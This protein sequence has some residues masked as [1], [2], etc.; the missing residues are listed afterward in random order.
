MDRCNFRFLVGMLAVFAG[1]AH[2]APY[3]NGRMTNTL[4]NLPLAFEPNYGQASRDARFLSRAPGYLL[5]LTPTEVRM[6]IKGPVKAHALRFAWL[7]AN[8]EARVAPE[9]IL[10]GHVNYFKGSDPAKWRTSIPTYER[11]RYGA[12][13]R[14]IDLVYYGTGRQLEYDLVVAPHADPGLPRLAIEGAKVDL[15]EHGDLNLALSDGRILTLA[16]PVAYQERHGKRLPI[17]AGYRLTNMEGRAEVSFHV[18]SYDHELPLII[19]PLVYSTFL[20]GSG[21]DEGHAIAVNAAGEAFVTG[22]S[23]D[24]ATDFPTTPGAFAVTHGGG[25]D[26][27]VTRVNAAGSAL[28]YSTFLGGNGSDVGNGI[29]I[30]AANEAFVTG[31]TIGSTTFFPTT[32]GA[33]ST[34]NSGSVDAFVTRLNATGS[35]LVYSTLLGGSGDDHGRAI[36]VS[37][38]DEAFVTGWTVDGVTDYPTTGGAFD[39]THNGSLDV[40]VTRLNAAGSSLVYSTLLGGSGEDRG[41]GIAI[42]G[43][44][45]AFV[46]GQTADAVTDFPTTVGAFDTTHNGSTDA[47]VTRLNATGTALVYS[48]FL[49]G[50]GDDYGF[51]IAVNG[52]E[53]FVAGAAG[54]SVNSFP[55]TAGAFDPIRDGIIDAFVTRMNAAGSGLIYSTFLGADVTQGTGIAVNA[56]GEAFVTGSTFDTAFPTTVGA[57]DTT[58][59]G[60]DDVFVT[61]L[62]AT[63][64]ALVYSTFL[65]GS[66]S[67]RLAAIA[68]NGTSDAFVTG[69]TSDDVTDFPTTVG[70]FDTT[71][72]GGTTDAFVAKISAAGFILTITGAGTGAGTVTAPGINCTST[73]GVVSGDC[74][75]S[76]LPT[77]AVTLTATPAGG[78]AFAGWTGDPDCTDGS[79]AMN[80][81]KTCTAS[82][83]LV[84]SATLT[85]TLAGTGTG[86]VTSAPAGIN[87]PAD[88]SEAYTVGTVVTLTAT[89]AAGSTFIGWSG[90]ADC[91]DGIVT[92][93]VSKSCTAT[94]NLVPT[95]V[96]MLSPWALILMSLLLIAIA[97]RRFV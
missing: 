21:D 87:C 93:D 46:T 34:T 41:H 60:Q 4:A 66:G 43:I 24:A 31:S 69:L 91:S 54:N 63:G 70:A 29:A 76:F 50:S 62:N 26:V 44:G 51:S 8:P 3:G 58:H 75:E 16:S 36:A 95:A 48:T 32:V 53:A 97:L 59:N 1:T 12:I 39:T 89:P 68:I 30:N 82:F 42:N 23:V 37:G 55:T 80:A 40:F 85:T 13:Y 72:N 83:T 49:G 92:M 67:E 61:R 86:T 19:D 47:F 84:P 74:S 20:G 52:N 78:S 90:N 27:F 6:I 38:T 17:N 28:I 45:E 77:T 94:F 81:D 22:Y 88:C 5:Q 71:H 57:A 14:G 35:G 15:T 9:S 2:A 25:F 56:T 18:A 7:G 11:V 96:P 64:S 79:V 73:A 65:G 33:F 10:P